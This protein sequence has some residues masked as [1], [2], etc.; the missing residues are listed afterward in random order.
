MQNT[1]T[2][3][4]RGEVYKLKSFN[5]YTFASDELYHAMTD[6][7][8]E[9]WDIRDDEETTNLDRRIAYFFDEEDFEENTPLQ[10]YEIYN[11]HS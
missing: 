4:Y 6:P 1:E 7:E 5:D 11:L 2:I 3:I 8:G 10:L 9:P